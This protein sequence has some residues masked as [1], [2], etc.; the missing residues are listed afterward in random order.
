MNTTTEFQNAKPFP[1]PKGYPLLG[2]IPKMRGSFLDFVTQMWLEYGDQVQFDVAKVDI[3]LVVHPD[4]MKHVLQMN[5]RNYPKGLKYDVKRLFGNGLFSSEGAFWRQ[6]RRLIQPMFNHNMLASYAPAIIS[7]TAEILAKWEARPEPSRPLHIVDEMMRLTQRVIARTMFTK[8]MSQQS[9]MMYKAFTEALD[10]LDRN[11][12]RPDFMNKWPIPSN[13][14]FEKAIETID[15]TMYKLIAER[16]GSDASHNEEEEQDLLSLLLNVRDEESGAGMGDQQIRDEITTMFLA[17]H[18]T[19]AMTLAWTWYFLSR[20][21]IVGQKVY[22]EV[23]DVLGGRTP[24]VDDLEKL[25]YT[26]QVF[27]ETLRLYP[28]AWMFGRVPL[29]DDVLPSGYRIPKGSQVVLLPYLTHRHPDFWENPEGFQPE[30]FTPEA[31]KSRH[32]YAYLPFS[33]GPRL[34]IG[35]NFALM[36]GPLMIAMIAQRY[37]LEL[38]PGSN[39]QLKPSTTLRPSGGVPML[40]TPRTDAPLLLASNAQAAQNGC[41]YHHG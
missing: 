23:D 11:I 13:R 35:N 6:Q 29:E 1:G 39:V 32:R 16:R 26:R 8:D 31:S 17:G 30:R 4:D 36:E 41:P 34:C 38:M 22:A 37:K 27:D 15:D 2:V 3:H 20:H 12:K 25:T 9:D 18:E 10:G 40:L 24:T 14:R 21:P 28:P 7:S 33:A 5:N 19:T